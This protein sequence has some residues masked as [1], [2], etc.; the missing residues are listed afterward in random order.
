MYYPVAV[1]RPMGSK[2]YREKVSTL[3]LSVLV[4]CGYLQQGGLVWNNS[5]RLRYHTFFIPSDGQWKDAIA[6]SY[7]NFLKVRADSEAG[8]AAE[9]V[10]EMHRLVCEDEER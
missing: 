2:M 9:K 4:G 5:H 8:Y 7:G 3:L 6:F 10:V 1:K